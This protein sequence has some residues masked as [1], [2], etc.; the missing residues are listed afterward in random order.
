MEFMEQGSSTVYLSGVEG[1][2]PITAIP[3]SESD[4]KELLQMTTPKPQ[5]QDLFFVYR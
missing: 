3:D 4:M 5:I 1:G 2:K